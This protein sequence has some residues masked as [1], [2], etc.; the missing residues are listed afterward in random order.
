MSSPCRWATVAALTILALAGVPNSASGA[1]VCE[2]ESMRSPRAAGPA[3]T[4][5]IT[6]KA[7][8]A[9]DVVNFGGHRNQQTIEV[10]MKP[11]DGT[12]L[13]AGLTPDQ[14]AIYTPKQFRRVSDKE[15]ETKLEYPKFTEPV[16]S[17]DEIS[18][19]ACLTG[20]NVKAGRY[21]GEIRLRGPD[22]LGPGDMTVTVN[23]KAGTG[24]YVWFIVALGVAM[25]L[26]WFQEFRKG[27][28]KRDFGLGFLI[29]SAGALLAAMSAMYKVY[30]DDPSWGSDVFIAG[31]ALV[32]TAFSAAGVKA[33][34]DAL[35]K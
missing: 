23:A 18:F 2:R 1:V 4:E 9:S 10:E 35:R 27:A 25:F 33:F 32:G 19:T 5:A 13:P 15:E 7:E 20:D 22:G 14:L 12:K 16:I 29:V 24:F 6:L 28:T 31:A 34:Y 11:P 21:T 8:P 26:L 17:R 30:Y 3:L